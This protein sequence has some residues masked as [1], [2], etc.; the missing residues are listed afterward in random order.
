MRVAVQLFG[1]EPDAQRE[2]F[3]KLAEDWA[4]AASELDSK[5]KMVGDVGTRSVLQR[6][7]TRVNT[8]RVEVFVVS[9]AGC[10][11]GARELHQSQW[12]PYVS[13]LQCRVLIV[14]CTVQMM[15]DKS[16]DPELAVLARKLA[17]NATAR[18]ASPMKSKEM[19]FV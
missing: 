10:V 18:A 9:V 19:K 12:R 3:T 15:T 13:C 17:Q 4:E 1:M 2:V 14:C 8:V 5:V 6:L 7:V 16:V 11:V